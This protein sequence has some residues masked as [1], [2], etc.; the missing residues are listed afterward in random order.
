MESSILSIRGVF[1]PIVMFFVLT[2][3]LVTFQVIMND[4][5]KNMIKIEDAVAFID[6]V[7]VGTETE[8]EYDNTVEKY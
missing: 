2:S 3:S 7:M 8:K 1:E 5:L 6:D 4:L